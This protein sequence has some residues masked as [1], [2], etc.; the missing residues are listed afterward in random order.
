MWFTKLLFVLLIIICIIFYV[1]YLWDFALVLLAAVIAVPVLMFLSGLI[2]KM[3]IDVDF[4]LKND[5]VSKNESFPVQL[6][7]TNRSIFPVGKAEAHI[8]YSNLCS[9]EVNTFRL[10]MPIQ[11][12]NS[13]NVSFQL[14]SRYCGD[15]NV[16]CAY[17]T[18][19]DPMKIFKFKVG[20]NICS[21]ISVLPE[22]SE[23]NGIVTYTDRVNEESTTFS[24]HK[25][26][27]DPSEVFDLR[28][29][30]PGDKLNRIH[31]KLS[32]KKDEF[33]V[34]DYSLPVDTPC[35]IFLDL[36]CTRKGPELLPVIDTLAGTFVSLS[37]FLL[38]NERRH[39]VVYFNRGAG[40]FV[41]KDVC[42]LSSLSELTKEI[43]SSLCGD[44]PC[45][46]PEIYLSD[47]QLPP[48]SSFTFIT[49]EQDD[50]AFGY[51]QTGIDAELKNIVA[52]VTS[53]LEADI[54]LS[55]APGMEII[56]VIIGRV[57]S[58]IKDIEI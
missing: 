44:T 21:S 34:K 32:S 16:R 38:E 8:E 52:V 40:Q 51:I 41:E 55:S 49:S 12:R 6:R 18:I 29:Y 48:L 46:P 4:V 57:S 24:E 42:D 54:L 27:D 23:I 26:G 50:S 39:S 45:Q 43:I 28:S 22:I 30:N 31:W 11:A 17:V 10:F 25:P 15:L 35:T 2:T 7:V 53:P 5:T 14:L 47:R 19:C 36:H 58:S 3:L 56:P 20:K 37:H 33:I 9:G 13:Q 1:M